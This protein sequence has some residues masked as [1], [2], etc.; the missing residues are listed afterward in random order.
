MPLEIFLVLILLA[1]VL[2]LTV[3]ANNQN[4]VNIS[5]P[6]EVDGFLPYGVTTNNIGK[7]NVSEEN[8]L[9]EALPATQPRAI[10][11]ASTADFKWNF[12]A[13]CLYADTSTHPI[14]FSIDWGIGEF[15]LWIQPS[16][17]WFYNFRPN[18][19]IG[20]N[21]DSAGK[22]IG[23][24]LTLNSKYNFEVLWQKNASTV[25]LSLLISSV[26]W[27]ND[28]IINA[29]IP[30]PQKSNIEYA[31]LSF[32]SWANINNTSLTIFDN[33]KLLSYNSSKF[34]QQ[35]PSLNILLIYA[36]LSA[37]ILVAVGAIEKTRQFMNRPNALSLDFSFFLCP[38]KARIG[39]FFRDYNQ[40]IRKYWIVIS[41]FVFFGVFRFVIASV[42]PGHT[43]D[44]HTENAWL[45][46]IQTKGVQAIFPLSDTLSPMIGLRPVFPY[47][48][49][50]AYMLALVSG[51]GQPANF[52]SFIVRLPGI[53]GDLFLGGIIFLILRKRGNL[54]T[55]IAALFLSL[56]NFV[57][58]SIWGQY[59]S[60]VAIFLILAVWFVATKRAGL[61]WAFMA[62]AVCTK[63]TSLVILPALF[64]LSFRQKSWSKII[65]GVIVFVTVFFVIWYP[66]IQTGT[67][68]DFALGA[69]GLRLWSPGGGLDPV[70]P[71][72]GGGTSIWA[73]NIWP[74]ITTAFNGQTPVQSII[75]SFKDTSSNQFL[76]FSYFQLGLILFGLVYAI[77]LLRIWKSSNLQNTIFQFGLIML[78]F[79]ILPT[80]VHERYL[81]FGLAFLPLFY[82]KSKRIVV[83]YL[84]LL[85]TFS[86]TLFYGL[87]NG[88]LRSP[89]GIFDSIINTL[90]SDFGL[91]TLC[92]IN[93][94]VFLVLMVSTSNIFPRIL[95]L[96]RL[97]RNQ[98]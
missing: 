43:F 69:S 33:S 79:Y 72:G 57:D 48:P 26:S 31:K 55:A 27:D 49:I 96:K 2:S 18:D 98:G 62:L 63:Q 59:D 5:K 19:T 21:W 3:F 85:T 9:I 73:F 50:I 12:S 41:L 30:V 17:G 87:T 89:S 11:Y 40:K 65:Y 84:I 54:A 36:T 66:F 6:T 25:D 64:I 16:V 92:I 52:N 56:L 38:F 15:L 58:S 97:N 53:V 29:K 14:T 82:G 83:S 39:Y 37:W 47:P 35:S 67:S 22:Y 74:L 23:K 70:A 20:D 77:L 51:F 95:K 88:P 61:G 24:N 75:G 4:Q 7:I 28:S 76:I 81:F 93:I 1:T 32:E 13:T 45:N 8:I 46:I 60:V 80:R 86:L 68:T 34:T 90:F 94:A 44:I 78:A 10:V 91:L 71:E 42:T